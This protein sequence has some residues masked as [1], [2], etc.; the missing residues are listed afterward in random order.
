[1]KIKALLV[2]LAFVS[3]SF[4]RAQDTDTIQKLN[5]TWRA[6]VGESDYVVAVNSIT[7]ACLQNYDMEYNGKTYPVTE[8]GI[9]TVGGAAARFYFLDEQASTSTAP[10]PVSVGGVNVGPSKE[11]QERLKELTKT[12]ADNP[13][14]ADVSTNSN[15]NT[16]VV[17]KFPEGTY[18]KTFEFRLGSKVE[19]KKLY[20]SLL[21]KW[22]K[23]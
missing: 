5:P 10:Q 21:T 19:V 2:F 9:E 14:T 16:R 23:Q 7:S 1:M 15:A 4:L 6:T 8:L 20:E 22:I 11:V 13:L 17:K 3:V 18:A 12:A